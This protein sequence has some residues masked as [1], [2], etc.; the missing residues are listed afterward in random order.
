MRVRKVWLLKVSVENPN[1]PQKNAQ[2]LL[3]DGIGL[4][5]VNEAGN[6][7]NCEIYRRGSIL[8]NSQNHAQGDD[9]TT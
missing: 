8:L 4:R 1:V 5:M 7:P 9:S 6:I 3:A 2:S